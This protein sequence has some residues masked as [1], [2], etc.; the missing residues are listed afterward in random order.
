M[1]NA[2]VVTSLFVIASYPLALALE[3]IGVVPFSVRSLPAFVSLYTVAGIL[4][5]AFGDYFGARAPRRQAPSR[6]RSA[7]SSQLFLIRRSDDPKPQ[8]QG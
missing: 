3:T 2:F 8:P 7:I 4:A 5:L 6:Q 1:K